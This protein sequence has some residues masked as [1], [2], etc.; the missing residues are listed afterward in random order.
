MAILEQYERRPFTLADAGDLKPAALYLGKGPNAVEVAVFETGTRPTVGALRAAWKARLGGRATP[1]VVV[2]L[3]DS[4]AALCGPAGEQPPAYPDIELGR[5]ERICSTALEEPDRHAALRFLTSAL[6]E[7][8]QPTS[9]LRNQGFFASHELTAGVPNRADWKAATEKAKGLLGRRDRELLH[10]LGFAVESLPGQALILRAAE[11]RIA[12]AILLERNESPD[13]ASVRF[14]NT[15]PISYALAKAEAENLEYVV[16]LAGPVLR[17]YPVKTGVGTGQRGRSETFVEIHLDLLPEELAGYLWLLFSATGLGKVGSVREI[18]DNSSR[19]AAHLG[20]RLRDRIYAEVIPALAQGLIVA[21]NLQRPTASD[22]VETYQMTLIVLFRLLFIAYAEDKEL[23]PYKSNDLYRA[24]SLK[25]KANDLTKL[26]REDK[27][28][29]DTN[30]SHWEEVERLFRAVDHGNPEWGVPQYNGGLFSSDA[31]VSKIGAAIAE[32]RVPDRVFGPVLAAL[33]VDR[34]PEGPGPVDFRSLGVREFG[35]IYEGLLENELAVADTDLTIETKDKEDRYRPAK[36]KEEVVVPKGHPFLHNTS[37]ARKSTGSFFTKHFAVEH[38][39]DYGIEPALKDHIERL[40]SMTDREAAE[41]FFDFRVADIAMG[42]GHFLVAAVDRIE[43]VLSSY[44]AQRP[45]PDVAEELR[46][47]RETALLAVRV[48]GSDIEIEDTQLLRRQIARR[49]IYGVDLNPIAVELA[50]LAIW[51]HT[52]VP[53]LPLSFLDHN[54]VVGNSLVGIATIDEANEWLREIAGSLFGYSADKLIGSAAAGLTK[55]ARLSDASAA[56]IQRARAAVRE[57]RESVRAAH[58]LFDILS[59]ARI[60]DSIRQSVFQDASHWQDDLNS[61]DGSALH[62]ESLKTLTAISSF[63]FPI[64]FPEVFLR[65]RPGFDLILGNPPWEEATV[66]EDRFWTRHNPGFHSLKQKEQESAKKHL[67]KERP[68]LVKEYDN[69]VAQAKLLRE[70]LVHG[71]YPGMGTGDPD[72]YKAACWR[73]WSLVRAGGG[74]VSVVLPRSALAAKGSREFRLAVFDAAVFTD[75][76]FLLNRGGWVFDDAEPRYT[77]AL[78]SWCRVKP[79]ENATLPIRGPFSTYSRFVQGVKK[80]PSSFLVKDV[81]SWSDAAALPLFPSDESAGVFAQLRKHP[82]FDFKDDN[83]WRARPHAEL[84]ATNDK[85]LMKFADE[86]P[87][88]FWPVFKGESFDIWEPDTGS[89]YAWAEP[90]KVLRELQKSRLRSA[91]LARSAFRE[92]ASDWIKDPDTLPCLYARIAFRDITR[93]TDT[94]TVRVALLPP[95]VFITNK[96]PY[97]LWPRGD[98]KDEAYVLGVLASIPLDWYARRFVEVGLNFHIL[99]PF[100]IPR[101]D[102]QSP[103]WQRTVSLAGQLASLD[104]RFA[105]WAKAVGVHCRKPK[106]DEKNDMIHELDAVIAHLYGLTEPQLRH[107]FETFHE[108]WEYEERLEATLV[109]FKKW[110]T[111]L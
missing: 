25:Q 71:P 99:E 72:V 38:L 94:R 53:G 98:Q 41:S 90:E 56:E 19:Y 73:F 16:V 28:F 14:S 75:L 32:L 46:R 47:L 96:G 55:L 61:L 29:G 45:L 69:E 52:F 107:I 26:L 109:H 6:P 82:R 106:D 17:L 100:P 60:N 101:P 67:R 57:A 62:T 63:H 4:K 40:A 34:T 49:C 66:E 59:A 22:L 81:I 30:T 20:T 10:G 64:A 23:L 13:V 24:R 44:L 39:L 54:L 79:D 58:A 7:L 76:T 87:E 1:L 3:Y 83:S 80:R 35:T 31:A 70:L 103:L 97:L 84:H 50:R 18:L 74:R 42:S 93:A 68:D 2:A 48:S 102:R 92:F 43:R 15:S 37:G 8:E 33:L 86:Q 89:Y 65:N 111:R 77:I 27:Q 51:I 21:R 91:K 85:P 36:L 5:A 105:K 11:S 108:G 88:D 12:L 110:Q 78:V 9:G 95:N 104:K